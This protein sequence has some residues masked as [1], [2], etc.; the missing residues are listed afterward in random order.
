MI[1]LQQFSTIGS[2]NLRF[3]F[4]CLISIPWVTCSVFG[5]VRIEHNFDGLV[6]IRNRIDNLGIRIM[7]PQRCPHSNS[8]KCEYDME[9]GKGYLRLLINGL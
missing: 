4:Q 5:Q 6:H 7:I 9:R 8:R 3:K 2:L 1:K